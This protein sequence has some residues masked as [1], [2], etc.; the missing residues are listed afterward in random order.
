MADLDGAFALRAVA[1]LAF[2]HGWNGSF[3]RLFTL[4]RAAMWM[5]REVGQLADLLWDS[6]NIFKLDSLKKNSSLL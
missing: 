4:L 1:F 5:P 2:V 3:S 6:P